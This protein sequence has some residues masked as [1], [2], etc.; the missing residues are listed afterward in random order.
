MYISSEPTW[1]YYRSDTEAASPSVNAT[2][3]A[4]SSSAELKAGEDYGKGVVFYLK[5]DVV[6]GVLMWNIFNK[7]SIARKVLRENKKYEDLSEVAKL[8][9]IH[10]LEDQK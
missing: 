1:C 7:I 2:S 4:K 10:D 6:V 3:E 5:E 9:D 8:F